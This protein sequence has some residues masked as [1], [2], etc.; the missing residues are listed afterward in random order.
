MK[1]VIP[2]VA[3]LAAALS[4]VGA[5]ERAHGAPVNATPHK[6]IHAVGTVSGSDEV[7]SFSPQKATVKL[8]TK[9]TWVNDSDV[10]HSV[11]S[12]SSKWSFD[13]SVDPGTVITFTFKKAGTYKYH[14]IFH[15]DQLGEIV[16]H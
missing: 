9:I 8:G 14:C 6:S 15:P 7:Y 3:A 5:A 4:L 2:S 13:K 12:S 11:T 1:P 10:T 16:V